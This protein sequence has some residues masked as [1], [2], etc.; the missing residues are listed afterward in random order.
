M[1][2][3]RLYPRQPDWQRISLVQ[4]L[5]A[6]PAEGGHACLLLPT[7]D[8]E[9][10]SMS[11]RAAKHRRAGWIVRTSKVETLREL[12]DKGL[13]MARAGRLGLRE[14]VPHRVPGKFPVVVK[15]ARGVAGVGV[16]IA[17]DAEQLSRLSSSGSVVQTYVPG[18]FEHS[19][20][21]WMRQ[22]SIVACLNTL[23]EYETS[24]YTWPNAREVSRRSRNTIG[25]TE[26]RVFR[27]LLH[28]YDGMCN[29]NYKMV[30]RKPIIL[31]INV[32]VGADLGDADDEPTR[33]FLRAV[34]DDATRDS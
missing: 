6:P 25:S 14:F 11:R 5:D 1:P 7:S 30:G 13:L 4:Y 26:R 23:Y 21:L 31:E 3:I 8:E 33:K 10:I 22:G 12:D 15:P 32:R 20:L 16:H 9:A 19:T 2:C 18:R 24:V 27:K 34:Y 17:M 28:D 29:V